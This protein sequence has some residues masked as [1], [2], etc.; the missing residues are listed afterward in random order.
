[1]N[2]SAKPAAHPH[3]YI[4]GSVERL[5]KDHIPPEG[6]FPKDKR[7][8][9]IYADCCHDCHSKLSMDDEV[10]RL[11]LSSAINAS[12]SGKWICE[13]KAI[14]RLLSK[15]KL[16]DNIQP[17]LRESFRRNEKGI[18]GKVG[19]MDMLQS[20]AVPFIRRM[21][22]GFIYHL[23]PEYDYFGDTFVVSRSTQF[24]DEL[25]ENI[26]RVVPVLKHL[27]RGQDVFKL[28]YSIAADTKQAGIWV[29]LFYDAVLMTCIH[30]KDGRYQNKFSDS[31]KEWHGLPKHL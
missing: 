28:W 1:M 15:P 16:H 18:I 4:C 17:Y 22:K 13:H 20:R 31:Y 26:R 3:C 5:T 27:E 9:L 14:P 30:S 24:R 19:E 8:E 11:W 23:Y 2:K 29:F 7:K 10:M 12:A 6:F 25:V 21:T